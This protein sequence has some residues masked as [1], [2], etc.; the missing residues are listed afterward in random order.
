MNYSLKKA[1]RDLAITLVGTVLLFVSTNVVEVAPSMGLG[2]SAA[3]LIGV[4][5]LYVYRQVRE[6]NESMTELDEPGY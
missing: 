6:G 1:L 4:I 2:E 3:S 5:S